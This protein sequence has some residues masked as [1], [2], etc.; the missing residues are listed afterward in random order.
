MEAITQT[1]PQTAAATPSTAPPTPAAA[2][3]DAL[4]GIA[5]DE[6]A[7][8]RDQPVDDGI[9]TQP[10]TTE[11]LE[12]T[13]PGAAQTDDAHIQELA[14]R[15][16]VDPTN[17]AIAQMLADI[18]AADKLKADAA[19]PLADDWMAEYDKLR[20]SFAPPAPVALPA[21]PLKVDQAPPNNGNNGNNGRLTYG[22]IGDKWETWDQSHQQE[23]EAL[24]AGNYPVVQQIQE[25]RFRRMVVREALPQFEAMLQ[26]TLRDFKQ[27]ELTDVQTSFQQTRQERESQQASRKALTK[28]AES[29]TFA[30]VIDELFKPETG[31]I[32]IRNSD[33]SVGKYPNN[34]FNR[35]MKAFPEWLDMIKPGDSPDVQAQKYFDI[36]GFAAKFHKQTRNTGLSPGKAKELIEQGR[37][38]EK[39]T[40]ETERVRQSMNTGKTRTAGSISGKKPNEW[41]DAHS[42]SGMPMSDLFHS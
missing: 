35:I 39:R 5:T 11:D 22:D 23:I 15:Y 41:A 40:T 19:A 27:K 34:A 25:A 12:V 18:A 24:Q 37:T 9:D 38:Q 42:T 28:L 2:P 1:A 7:G 36:Y 21:L 4:R 17:P 16:G 8:E 20:A 10:E 13:E 29:T 33:G 30:P 26:A 3:G 31:T 14:K 32:E 6:R